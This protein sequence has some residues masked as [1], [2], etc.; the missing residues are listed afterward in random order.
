MR[1]ERATSS[2]EVASAPVA[3][4]RPQPAERGRRRRDRKRSRR[5]F[6]YALLVVVAFLVLFPLYSALVVA[7]QPVGELTDMGML[8][9]SDGYYEIWT[10]GTDSKGAMQPHMAGFWNP[11][12]YGGNPMHRVAVLVG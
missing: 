4:D 10:R 9:P 11:Q 3:V 7:I 2:T 1:T 12:G 6:D 8:L 5:W